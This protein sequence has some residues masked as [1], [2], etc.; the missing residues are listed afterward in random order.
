MKY[1]RAVGV[2]VIIM[3]LCSL[4]V[5]LA[6][7]N[8]AIIQKVRFGQRPDGLRIVMDM[9][10]V[11]EYKVTLEQEPLR[12]LIDMP[13]TVSKTALPQIM[14]NDPM[15]KSLEV[16]QLEAGQ[17]RAIVSLNMMVSHK[18]YTLGSP[19]RLVIDLTKIYERKVQEEVR[20]GLSYISWLRGFPFGPVQSHILNVDLKSG[21]AIKPMLSNGVVAGLETVG[22]MSSQAKAI[23]AVNGSYFAPNGEIIGLLKMD[24]EII[25][26]PTLP[27]SAMGILPDGRVIIDQVSFS[28]GVVLP[29]GREINIS[30]VNRE[31]GVNE[32]ILYNGYYGAST[33]SNPYGTEYVISPQGKVVAINANNSAIESG[34]VVLSAHGEA[35]KALASLKVGDTVVI[36]ESLGQVWDQA[37]HALG[38]GPMLVKNGSVFLTTK[39]EEFGSDV[40]G[41]RAPRTALG[42]TKDGRLLLV[43]VDG[44]QTTSAGMTL[45]ELALF[46]Q[47]LGA[48]DALNL[49]GGGSS[50]MVLN[51]KILNKPSDGRERKVGD[52]LVIIPTNLLN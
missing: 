24:G 30:G 7:S 3:L 36:R 5:T 31:R 40:A 39:T 22:A 2:L 32:L 47:E 38:A 10:V 9:N 28:G 14:L 21:L 43:V 23:A 16:Q 44:R 11:P 8:P 1:S 29:S 12:L 25:S 37:V 26:T 19:N 42:L 49:D 35:V 50:E 17:V 34:C 4:S 45:L 33:G 20:P 46:M 41:G 6:A 15:V 27:R 51:D 13:A 52:A 18:V 48:V